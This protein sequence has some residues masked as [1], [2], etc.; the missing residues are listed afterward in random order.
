MEMNKPPIFAVF[1][2]INIYP[3]IINN[4]FIINNTNNNIF[5]ENQNIFENNESN[6]NNNIPSQNN[7]EVQRRKAI[8]KM[9]MNNK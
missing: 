3:N 9:G 1:N 8:I 6:V 7:N 2:N 4:N 5:S